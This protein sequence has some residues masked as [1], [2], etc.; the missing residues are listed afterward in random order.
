MTDTHQQP[1]APD[2]P[3]TPEHTDPPAFYLPIGEDEFES[4]VATS[5]PWDERAQHGGPPSALLARAADRCRPDDSMQVARITV[6]MLGPI[7]QGIVRTEAEVVRP[8]RRVELLRARLFANDTLAATAS[9]WRI[10]NDPGMTEDIADPGSAPALPEA[11]AQRYFPSMSPTWGYGRAVEWRFTTG[12]YD[13]LGNASAWVRTRVPLVAG[14]ESSAIERLLIVA[15]SVNGLSVRLPIDEWLSI[16]PTLT[17]SVL[18]TPIDEW[19]HMDSETTLGPN[20][21]GLASGQLRDARGL[22]AEVAQPLLLDRR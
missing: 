7:P 6:D 22:V 5:S 1:D 12:H 14:E 19:V 10:R 18:R 16:P 8:G 21:I 9:L 20:G 13:E 4:T 3:A 2:Q 11:Q 17:V 15:D